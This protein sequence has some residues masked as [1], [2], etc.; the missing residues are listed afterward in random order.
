MAVRK[1]Q[2]IKVH[3]STTELVS[4]PIAVEVPI[5]M[6]VNGKVFTITMCTPSDIIHLTY[7]LLYSE[8][9]FRNDIHQI[10]LLIENNE[11]TKLP[12][13]VH[14]SIPENLL[15]KGYQNSRSLLSAS[16]CGICGKTELLSPEGQIDITKELVLDTQVIHQ[17]YTQLE[18][19]QSQFTRSGGTHA[20]GIFNKHSQLLSIKE[21]IGRHNAVDKAIGELC[22]KNRLKEGFF[23]LVSGRI[24][25]EILSKAY[26][27]KIPVLAA[28][29]APSS[30]AIDY[31]K[32][33]GITLIG[34]S[35]KTKL[36]IY[37]HPERFF[38]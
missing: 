15:R 31:A 24:S 13:K 21:D 26:A 6:I 10:S 23:L 2:A 32:E 25:Y 30:L 14:V 16:S 38:Q 1:Y 4:D 19:N 33:L 18:S 17:M 3:N 34:F 9:V 11:E 36:T 12:E 28:V 22:E 8:D 35:R 5:T 20:A 7:G 29:S 27:A 37:A